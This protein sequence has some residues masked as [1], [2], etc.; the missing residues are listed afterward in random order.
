MNGG[1]PTVKTIWSKRLVSSIPTGD[2]TY[3]PLL[4]SQG[5]ESRQQVGFAWEL[6]G[7]NAD[8]ITKGTLLIQPKAGFDSVKFYAQ[9][10]QLSYNSAVLGTHTFTKDTLFYEKTLNPAF[11]SD[12][13]QDCY[14][15]DGVRDYSKYTLTYEPKDSDLTIVTIYG[16]VKKDGVVDATADPL[17]T[18]Q[19]AY[20]PHITDDNIAASKWTGYKLVGVKINGQDAAFVK[21][22]Q[23]NDTNVVALT[24]IQGTADKEKIRTVEFIYENNMTDVTIRGYYQGTTTPIENFPDIKVQAEIGKAYTYGQ[25]PL[26][27]YDSEGTVPKLDTVSGNSS[28]DILTYY[29]TKKQGNVTYRA[30]DAG[31]TGIVLARKN[32][33]AC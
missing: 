19:R 6:D 17:Y 24:N 32:R 12:Q 16:R 28:Q 31:N 20:S 3:G 23:N 1:R 29:Y 15:K 4:D 8:D 30:V 27:G 11:L 10:S 21:D 22:D 2:N 18:S 26:N 9:S 7:Y 13:N 14:E 5:K 25:L 33:N